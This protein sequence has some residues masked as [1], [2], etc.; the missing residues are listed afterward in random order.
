MTDTSRA[1]A[2]FLDFDGTLVDIAPRPDAVVVHPDL[3]AILQ[4]LRDRLGG[5]LAIVTGRPIGVIDALL[6]AARF[7]VAGLHGA[8]HAHAPAAAS[9]CCPRPYPRFAEV[10]PAARIV[11]GKAGILVEDKGCS[12]CAALAAGAASGDE[13]VTP[14]RPTPSGLG[15][16]TVF[17]TAR[18]WWN[19]CP[20][21]EQGR[22][23]RALLRRSRPIAIACPSS[24]ATT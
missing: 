7:D 1:Y 5:A 16:T 14:M 17:R 11:A 21:R 22:G 4:R 6:R 18:A 20:R 23:D 3:P 10:S 12:R 8:E 13:A 9:T 15:A 24:S 2:L 19:C